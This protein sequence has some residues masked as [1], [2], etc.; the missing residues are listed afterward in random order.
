MGPGHL[1]DGVE[2]DQ[3]LGGRATYAMDFL[4][5]RSWSTIS[6]PGWLSNAWR[7]GPFRMIIGVPMLPASGATLAQG[8]TGAYDQTFATLA[9]ALV[10]E[11]LGSSI[12]MIGWQP[13]DPG[14]PWF[15]D[16]PAA[17][18][19]YVAYW[20]DIRQTMAA[21]AGAHF[22]FE[23]DAGDGNASPVSPAAMYPGSAAVDIVATD[24]FDTLPEGVHV[25]TRWQ[26]V[27]N[28]RYGPDWMLHFAR[29]HGKPMAI[30]MWGLAPRRA[31]GAGDDA[32]FVS[33]FLHWAAAARIEMS[34]L[35]DYG[36]WALT[37]G[38]YPSAEAAFVRITTAARTT[39]TRRRMD[40][41]GTPL[42]YVRLRDVLPPRPDTK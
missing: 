9:A 4:S 39:A 3:E 31:H 5:E 40:V 25:S 14:Q 6:G 35:W 10:R 23:W 37:G 20:D 30:A 26:Y 16:S 22:T 29:S 34:V 21:V 19:S 12:L 13:D 42:P 17:A 15:V 33:H 41:A 7:G 24:A 27:L 1:A 38:S 8:A 32:A 11:G 2:I 18:R 36:S 28:R